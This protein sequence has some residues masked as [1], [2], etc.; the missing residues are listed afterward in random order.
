V[1]YRKSHQKQRPPK[2]F[3]GISGTLASVTFS[4]AIVELLAITIWSTNLTL[5]VTTVKHTLD[6]VSDVT[7]VTLTDTLGILEIETG[8]ASARVINWR[9][10]SV[11]TN[12]AALLRSF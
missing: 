11:C 3:S 9:V 12:A 10:N 1:G 6:A 4:S 5:T 2:G 7:G 8:A